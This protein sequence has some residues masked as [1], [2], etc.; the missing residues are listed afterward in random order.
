MHGPMKKAEC[1]GSSRFC[2]YLCF[3]VLLW[4]STKFQEVNSDFKPFLKRS[5][6]NLTNNQRKYFELSQRFL[7]RTLHAWFTRKTPDVKDSKRWHEWPCMQIWKPF[8]NEE[9]TKFGKKIKRNMLNLRK[10]SFYAEFCGWAR[11]SMHAIL[12]PFWNEWKKILNPLVPGLQCQDS[13]ALTSHDLKSWS[14]HCILVV[15]FFLSVR[16]LICKYS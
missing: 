11:F 15:S 10:E 4:D 7:L 9:P 1:E 8:W 2:R 5:K 12:N 3:F 6:G 14:I 13:L 16:P